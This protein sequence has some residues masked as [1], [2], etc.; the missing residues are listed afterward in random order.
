VTPAHRRHSTTLWR[1]IDLKT[2]RQEPERYRAALARRGAAEDFDALLEADRLWRALTEQADNLRARQRKSSKSAPTPDE[3]EALR[4][5]KA[6]LAVVEEQLGAAEQQRQILLDTI[7][8][9]PDPTAADGMAEEDAQV[10]RTWGEPPQFSVPPRDHLEI[11]SPAGWIDMARGARTSGSRFAYRIGDVALAEMALFRFALDR[12]TAQGFLPVLPP[13]LVSERAMY[14]TGYLPTD[15]HNLYVLEQ[16]GLYLAGTSE[17]AL[18]AIHMDER[19]EEEQLPERYTAFTTNFRR[20]A[21][22]AGKDTRGMFRVHQFDKVEMFVF[23]IPEESAEFH[24]YLLSLEE[25]LV[26]EL[27]LPYRVM[28]IAVGD[29]GAPAAKKYDIEAWFPAQGRY[30]EITS[31]SN[32]TDYQARRLNIRFRRDGRLEFVHTLNGTGITARALLAVMENFQDEG[33]VVAVPEALQ[34]F[35]A[36][37]TLG[38]PQ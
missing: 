34:Q 28:N 7:P 6:D 37:K 18:A 9:L 32:T 33:G 11:S 26:Q 14:G 4:Q 30:R 22:A 23:C 2:A 31:C 35:G 19:L 8:N 1:V 3:I 21:G 16:D 5:L 38:K 24:E 17:V 15:A 27:G 29:L 20:E 13:V 10:V 36:P 25:Q 12:I